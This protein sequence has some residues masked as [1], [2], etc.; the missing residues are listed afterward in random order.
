[1]IS[2][3]I[4]E[5]QSLLFPTDHDP[6]LFSRQAAMRGPGFPRPRRLLVILL[7]LALLAWLLVGN[8][9][10]RNLDLARFSAKLYRP[11]HHAA[12]PPVPAASSG[13]NKSA[14]VPLEAHIMSKCPDARDCLKELVVPAMENISS[15]VDF[16]LSFIGK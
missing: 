4:D 2:R 9:S 3:P 8:L 14:L 10:F 15:I 5:K 6:Q 16:N 7:P 11:Y 12:H 13:K 1:M